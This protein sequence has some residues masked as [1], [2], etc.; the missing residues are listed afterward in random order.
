M[1]ITVGQKIFCKDHYGNLH[2]G[3]VTE[4]WGETYSHS[5]GFRADIFYKNRVANAEFKLDAL[6]WYVFLDK[7]DVG[8]EAKECQEKKHWK[9]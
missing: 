3:T 4:I 2:P 8:K 7:K 5:A 6:G 9:S 1:G